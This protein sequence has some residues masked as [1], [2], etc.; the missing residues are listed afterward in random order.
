[1][2]IGWIKTTLWSP[3]IWRLFNIRQ[4]E[5]LL[6]LK[7]LNI[8]F[9]LE[10][11]SKNESINCSINKKQPRKA[12]NET[13]R[14]TLN[15]CSHR[16]H[17]QSFDR[18]QVFQ[19]SNCLAARHFVVV[20]RASAYGMAVNH[21]WL[22]NLYAVP[23]VRWRAHCVPV[24]HSTCDCDVRRCRRQTLER[25]QRA[26]QSTHNPRNESFFLIHE[27]MTTYLM[28]KLSSDGCCWF[29]QAK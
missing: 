11:E 9:L 29:S 10:R 25:V 22:L 2:R 8:S 28:R 3:S 21:L 5:L 27:H 20:G 12:I 4:I 6:E 19:L 16:S 17:S 15:L 26:R 24:I 7:A 18:I 23:S 14:A 13:V 1:M